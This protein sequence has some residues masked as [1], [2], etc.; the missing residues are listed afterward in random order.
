VLPLASVSSIISRVRP[1]SASSIGVAWEWIEEGL[2]REWIEDRNRCGTLK[3]E[4]R[5]CSAGRMLW[6]IQ[7]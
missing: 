4:P 3:V 7:R 2:S 6:W 5:A 1:P